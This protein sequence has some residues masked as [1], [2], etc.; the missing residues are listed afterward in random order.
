MANNDNLSAEQ[1]S[2]MLDVVKEQLNKA[3]G[4]FEDS[5]LNFEDEFMFAYQSFIGNDFALKIAHSNP[6][7]VY[8]ALCNLVAVGLSLSPV[9]KLANIIARRGAIVLDVGYIGL[10]QLAT[11]ASS[12]KWAR[13]IEVFEGD[14]F[15]YRGVSTEPLHKFNPFDTKTR[16]AFVGVYSVTKT[17]DGD[18]L[19]GFM[20]LAEI[21]VIRALSN[22]SSAWKDFFGEMSKKALIKR[23]SKTWPKGNGSDAF[24]NAIHVLNQHE[25]NSPDYLNGN[26]AL[27]ESEKRALSV[28]QIE[29]EATSFDPAKVSEAIKAKTAELIARAA[30]VGA[31]AA[32]YEWVVDRFTGSDLAY[33]IAEIKRAK[34]AALAED[35]A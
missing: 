10:I 24:E 27:V 17:Y 35:A 30:P 29:S 31:W 16:G 11:E 6:G 8:S 26:H 15:E 9:T 12:I 3:E 13:A 23:D 33:A 19:V 7:S 25:G 4:K 5:R 32:A 20:S 22:A 21:N 34:P 28:E 1:R 2:L 14:E 18:L